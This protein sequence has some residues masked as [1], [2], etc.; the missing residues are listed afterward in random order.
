MVI[1][2]ISGNLFQDM[3]LKWETSGVFS[4]LVPILLIFALVYGILNK[5]NLFTQRDK[6][7]KPLDTDNSGRAINAVIALA[8]GVMAI[9]L[10]IVNDF[11]IQLF[12]RMGIALS[13]LLVAL[14]LGG[15]FFNDQN[16]SWVNN[17]MLGGAAIVFAVTLINTGTATGSYTGFWFSDN[18]PYLVGAAIFIGLIYS[19]VK[20]G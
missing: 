6:D 5:M 4:H 12:P 15:L 1:A 2:L 9:R 14:I 13:I 8:V 20:R 16:K 3:F 10:P 11:F 18:W 7:G 19:I 17:T